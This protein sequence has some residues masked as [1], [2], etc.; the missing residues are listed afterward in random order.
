[1]EHDQTNVTFSL[2]SEFVQHTSRSVF[3]TGKAGTGKTTFLKHIRSVTHKNTV[4][5]APTGV[6]AINAGGMT[7][8]SFFQIPPAVFLPESQQYDGNVRVLNRTTLFQ[9]HHISN[10]KL[11][12]FR[13]LELLIIDEVSM[14]RCDLIDLIDVILRHARRSAQPFGGVQVLFIGDLF[15]LPPVAQQDE[16]ALLKDHY[17]STFFFHSRVVREMKPLHIELQKIY[18]QK[19][20]EFI[21]LLNHVRHNEVTE[22][23]IAVLN[24]RFNTENIRNHI[25]LTTHNYKADA[26]NLEELEKLPGDQFQFD[27]R[28]DG[29][30]LDRS[31]PTDVTLLLKKGARVMF[32]RN[33]TSEDKLFFNGKLAEVKEISD[34]NIIVI[35]SDG[36]EFELKREKWQNIKYTYKAESEKIEEQELGSFTQYPIRL[37]WAIT[38]HKSQGLTFENVIIDAGD[39]FTAGQVYVA[40]SRCTSLE[41]VVLSSKISKQQISTNRLVNEY[42]VQPG[43]D[44][45]MHDLL[46][47]E[48]AHYEHQRLVGLFNVDTV[49]EEIAV[50]HTELRGKK[51]PIFFEALALGEHVGSK[52]KELADVAEKFRKQLEQLLEQSRSSQDYSVVHQRAEKGILYFHTFLT[53]E[54][55]TKLKTHVRS[56]KGKRKVKQYLIDVKKLILTIQR[57]AEKLRTSGLIDKNLIQNDTEE[58][59]DKPE[60]ASEVA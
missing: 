46:P 8:H 26:I 22:E 20:F 6:A 10:N 55:L 36:A 30:F 14:V 42:S 31:F 35:F 17:Q 34:D 39:S 40:L 24:A 48:K 54:I 50:W 13:E 5:V 57:K 52:A 38:I 56:L 45:S 33:D 19:D 58:N 18:R 47:R 27:A 53:Q 11:E 15:Q 1:M 25:V 51:L 59:P 3:L 21:Q 9:Q 7:I 16:W 44:H 23:D 4:V 49:S 12:M 37:A 43:Q 41:G 2:A 32:I 28:I 60:A 29:E